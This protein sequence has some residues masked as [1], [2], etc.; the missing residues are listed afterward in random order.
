[1]PLLRAGFRKFGLGNTEALFVIE[2][3]RHLRTMKPTIIKLLTLSL[4]VL[5][6]SILGRAQSNDDRLKAQEHLTTGNALL[7]KGDA[8]QAALQFGKVVELLPAFSIGYINRGLA[9]ASAGKHAEALADADQALELSAKES[10][11]KVYQ[12]LAYQVKGHVYYSQREFKLSI[13]SYSQSIEREPA[14][15]K[16][17]NGRAISYMSL[18]QHEQALQDFGKAIELNPKLTQAYVNRSLVHKRMNNNAAAIRDLDA[19]LALDPSNATAYS[20]RAGNYLEL[21]KY[22][23]A[24]GD[25]TKAIGI[26]PKWE[27][28][29]NRGRANLDKGN[30]QASID[31]NS[32]AIKMDGN[33]SKPFHNRALAY[34]RLGQN[35]LAVE[36]LRKAIS[37]STYSAGSHYNLGYFLFRGGRY[38]EAGEEASKMISR[39]PAWR[40]PVILR[41]ESYAK[42]GNATRANADRAAA[43][44]LDP[45][46]KPG[47]EDLLIYDLEIEIRTGKN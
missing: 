3:A 19:A 35:P 20:N 41:A 39:F 16:F 33:S 12:A 15:A 45:A 37:L 38:S 14:N 2:L 17:Y 44:K 11:A 32:V 13:E 28:Y 21:K 42:L 43:A 10:N 40:A 47:E 36:D 46:W 18:G 6:F 22:D 29:Y 23:E 8:E 34:H 9:Y 7:Q 31:D 30:L 24:I 5:L 1:M 26:E 27:F 4:S 25:Y